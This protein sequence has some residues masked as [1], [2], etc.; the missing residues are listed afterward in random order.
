MRRII[1]RDRHHNATI[2]RTDV[3][4]LTI[5]AVAAQLNHQPAIRSRS[6]NGA[7]Y[8]L[9]HHAPVHCAKVDLAVHLGDRNP[10]VVCFD[11]KIGASW[12]EYLVANVPLIAFPR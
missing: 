6:T 8:S 3:E 4:S 5:P 7:A 12:N 9:Q 11:G 10:A 1:L 2:C